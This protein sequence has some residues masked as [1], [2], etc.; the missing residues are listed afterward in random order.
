MNRM[1]VK[2]LRVI[3]N[4][5][6]PFDGSGGGI[7]QFLMSLLRALGSLEGPEEYVI[8]S[9]PWYDSEWLIKNAG[10]NQRVIQAPQPGG[11]TGGVAGRVRCYVNY[12]LAPYV[13]GP[14]PD[15]V[16][17]CVNYLLAPHRDR[18]KAL[19]LRL[20]RLAS[21]RQILRVPQSRGFFESLGGDLVHFPYQ[22]YFATMLPSVYNP[23]DLQH[24]QFPEFFSELD[25]ANRELV[26]RTACSES[27]V[28]VADARCCK[29][30]IIKNYGIDEEK[31]KVI[32]LGS[33]TQYYADITEKT[34]AM[35]REKYKLPEV[36]AFYPA[37]TWPHK[38]HLQLIEAIK[39]LRDSG[40]PLHVVCTGTLNSYWPTLRHRIE[41]LNLEEY[42]SFLGFIDSVELR[43][44]YQLAQF[45]VFPSLFEGAGL[46][47]L[48]AFNEGVPITCSTSASIPEY[49]G[50]AALFF[51]PTS[52][53]SIAEALKDMMCDEQLRA[54]LKKK[55]A[56]R[57]KLFDWESIAK[58]YRA[59]YRQVAGCQLSDEDMHLLRRIEAG[60]NGV[61]K[62]CQ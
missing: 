4:A 7:Q 56:E 40:S 34:L 23:H 46:P 61:V 60:E 17:Y 30:D 32:L 62:N 11:V 31:I 57:I 53:E 20:R 5:Q 48:E 49:A 6:L 47:V 16:K 42:V 35:V 12:L 13:E 33:P 37:Q 1:R 38:N 19:Y 18:A 26:Y 44:L 21:G 14:N 29:S 24:L 39:V 9:S 54:T 2:P 43:A 58:T 45:V 50:D 8:V 10:P 59:L 41:D 22:E 15:L 36:F 27:V 51:D 52:P 25:F 55:G 3:I 28:V